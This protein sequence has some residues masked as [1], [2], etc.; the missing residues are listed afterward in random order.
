MSDRVALIR[1]RLQA[2]FSPSALE[3]LDESHQHAGH[4]GAASGRGHFR[5]RITAAAFNDMSLIQRHRAVYAAMGSLMDTHIHA[6]A[7]EA[8]LPA[9]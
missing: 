6:L 3:V 4:A 1:E 2:S 7:I 9:Q 5:V 8:R